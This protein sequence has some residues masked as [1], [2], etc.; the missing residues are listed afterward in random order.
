MTP[1]PNDPPAGAGDSGGEE[2]LIAKYWA[3]LAAEF[4]GAL[5]LKDD[6]AVIAPPPGSELI[7]TTDALIEG[8]HFVPGEDPGAIAWK[9]LAVNVSDLIAKGA[10][11]LAYLMSL[12]LPR[13]RPTARGCVPS[14]M[15][16][17]PR[18]KPSVAGWPAATPTARRGR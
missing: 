15:V 11:P 14:P 17:G 8:V 18:S 3:P 16:W 7:V 1:D 4:P 10:T 6:C 5:S 9:A 12:A 2:A 13:E